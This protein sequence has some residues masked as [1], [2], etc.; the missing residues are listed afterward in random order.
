MPLPEWYLQVGING[1]V[2]EQP[3]SAHSLSPLRRVQRSSLQ[4]LTANLGSTWKARNSLENMIAIEG[5]AGKAAHSLR[6]LVTF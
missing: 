4:D 1:E 5:F 6:I 2:K 3:R